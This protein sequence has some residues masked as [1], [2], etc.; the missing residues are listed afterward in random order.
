MNSTPSQVYV[1]K[2]QGCSRMHKGGYWDGWIPKRYVCRDRGISNKTKMNLWTKKRISVITNK[3]CLIA[4]FF[5]P[6]TE[7]TNLT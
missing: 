3:A 5:D 6:S 2:K 1:R 7:P 4:G